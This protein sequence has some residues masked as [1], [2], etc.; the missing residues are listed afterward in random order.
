MIPK[1]VIYIMFYSFFIFTSCG[2]NASKVTDVISGNQIELD[3]NHKVFLAGISDTEESKEYLI[4]NVLGKS[5]TFKIDAKASKGSSLQVYI[6]NSNSYSVNYKILNKGLAN[7]KETTCKDSLMSF[8]KIAKSYKGTNQDI[9]FESVKDNVFLIRSYDKY[10]K[11]LGFGTGFFIDRDGTGVSNHHVF[12]GGDSW[13]IKMAGDQLF[14]VIDIL[15]SN[16]ENDYLI[17]KVDLMGRARKGIAISE[18]APEISDRIFVLGNPQGLET[19]LSS[20][21]ISALRPEKSAIQIDAAVSPGSSGSPV[22]NSSGEVV[23]V[24]TSKL[25]GCENCNFAVDVKLIS[26]ELKQLR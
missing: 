17:F 10:G 13:N 22:I 6:K 8:K 21:I 16:E 1:K 26:K 5:C 24:V 25:I 23:A 2:N 3:F 19:T 15:A 20:G 18:I 12:E 14:P 4:Q 7:F 11:E 9:D